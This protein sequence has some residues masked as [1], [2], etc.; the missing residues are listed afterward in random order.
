[1]VAVGEW[2]KW[3]CRL[4]YTRYAAQGGVPSGPPGC[5]TTI[6]T[7]NTIPTRNK[8]IIVAQTPATPRRSSSVTGCI[9][10]HH[11]SQVPIRIES[12]LTAR[13]RVGG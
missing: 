10:C 5:P 8:P 12:Y 6:S 4:G 11:R 7:K 1:M 9:V 3:L 13:S 2:A